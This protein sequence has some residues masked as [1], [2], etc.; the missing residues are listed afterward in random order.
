[1]QLKKVKAETIK[2]ELEHGR[3]NDCPYCPIK[4]RTRAGIRE[5]ITNMHPSK[6]SPGGL[7]LP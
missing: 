5:H 3:N 4:R 6:V 7:L 2:R 1:M